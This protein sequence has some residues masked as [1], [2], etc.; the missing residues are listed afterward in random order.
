MQE[1]G[2]PGAELAASRDHGLGQVG[3]FSIWGTCVGAP[4]LVLLV[5]GHILEFG[6]QDSNPLCALHNRVLR[7]ARETVVLT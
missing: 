5:G 3:V 4:R 6:G 1:S 2:I 7:A